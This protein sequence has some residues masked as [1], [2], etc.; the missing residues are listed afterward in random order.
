MSE[1]DEKKQKLANVLKWVVGIPLVALA[2]P[3]IF[4][5][6]KGALGILAIGAAAA[7]GLTGLKLAPW[8]SM[9]VSNLAMKALV[10]EAKTNP[11][12]TLRNLH[13]EKTV[14]LRD[15]KTALVDF[16]TEIRNYADQ[17]TTFKKQWPGE[18]AQYEEVLGK[19]KELLL[20]QRQD[21]KEFEAT[22]VELEQRISRGEAHMA[23]ALA[24]ARVEKFSGKDEKKVFQQ[25]REKVAFQ[26]IQ[27]EVNRAFAQLD[28]RLAERQNVR[29]QIPASERIAIPEGVE[30]KLAVPI[31]RKS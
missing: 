27:T 14:Q 20:L 1:A 13:I 19:M 21:L 4:L 7:V 3:L 2:T 23:M 8:F 17:I 5:A 12:E 6:L 30:E 22:L 25:I 26:A 11:I 29:N 28:A 24:T 16:D 10:H 9:K 18:S 31:S 15:A